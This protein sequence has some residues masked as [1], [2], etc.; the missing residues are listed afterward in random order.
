MSWDC[1]LVKNGEPCEVEDKHNIAGGTYRDG[2]D[3]NL[4]IS[5]TYNYGEVYQMIWPDKRLDA[6]VGVGAAES[7][8]MLH[9][10]LARLPEARPYKKDYW[11]PTIGNARVALEGMLALAKLAPPDAVWRIS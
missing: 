8:A 4:W 7:F 5:V 11:A 3:N 9:E 1:R 6:F 2:G 10:A